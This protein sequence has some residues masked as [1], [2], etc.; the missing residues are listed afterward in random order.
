MQRPNGYS[1]NSAPLEESEDG[2]PLIENDAVPPRCCSARFNLAFLMFLGFSVVYGLRV[3]LSVAMVAMVNTTDPRPAQNSSVIR[4]CPLPAGS[5]NTSGPFLQPEGIPQYPWDSET[6]GWLLGAFFFGYLCTQIPGGYL[7][8]HY[9]GS[10][11]LGLGV[12][13]TAALTLLTPLAARMGSYWLFALRALEG[14]GEGVTYPSMMSMWARWAP[15]MERSRLMTLSGCGGNFGAF[16]ALPLTGYICQTLGWPAV[17][18][19]C[20]G[21]GCLWAVFWFI[22]VSDDPR[23]HRRISKEERDYIINSIGPQGTGHGWSLPLLPMLLSV[24]LWAIIVTQMCSNFSYY[25]LLTSLPTYMDN[26]LH[27]DLKSNG[28]LSALPYLGAWLVSMLSGVVADSLIERKVFGTTVVRKLFTLVGV[29]PS[30]VFL[31]AV[32][33]VGCSHILTVTFLTLSTT[34][35]GVTAPGVYINQIDIAPRYA[36]FLLGITNTFGTIPGV[37]APIVTGYFTEDHTLAG[38]SKVFWLAAG[39]NVFGA[40]VY[41]IFGSGKL[42]PWA[43][44]EEERAED[45]KDRSGSIST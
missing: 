38:W 35:G 20:G 25:T 44:T 37:L 40:L 42:Q 31:V 8:G 11:F 16:V 4:A 24:P 45:E 33:Y 14:F 15:P 3:N 9:G 34:I 22:F 5:G 12:L 1:I 19:L 43:V 30:A 2:E 13:G 29:L 28:F 10:I 17:F 23:T 7:S 41:T 27:F 6:Q 21:A 36:G 32:N 39:V 18:Y 26:I